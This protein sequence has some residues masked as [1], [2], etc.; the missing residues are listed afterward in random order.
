MD[1]FAH[2]QN[3]ASKVP[4]ISV[5]WD[6]WYLENDDGVKADSVDSQEHLKQLAMTASEGI[7]ALQC[8][9]AQSTARQIIVSTGPL[10]SRIEQWIKETLDEI[11]K[12]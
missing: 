3:Q 8:I 7:D 9:L 5:N 2:Q 1:A 4:W 6:S 12:P 11:K 10:Q